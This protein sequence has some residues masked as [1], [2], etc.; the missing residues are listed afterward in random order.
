MF[1]CCLIKISRFR[2]FGMAWV[3]TVSLTEKYLASRIYV[4]LVNLAII[5]IIGRTY[6]NILDIGVSGLTF[7]S[8]LGDVHSPECAMLGLRKP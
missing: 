4:R 6:I 2:A 8:L 1:V 5:C 7:C 3:S